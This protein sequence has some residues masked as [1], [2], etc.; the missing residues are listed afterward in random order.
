METNLALSPHLSKVQR[1]GQ[2]LPTSL[3]WSPDSATVAVG[4]EDARFVVWHLLA[5]AEPEAF[6]DV[7]LP[8]G[9]TTGS[10]P[11]AVLAL[12]WIG[13]SV[14][15]VMDDGRIVTSDSTTGRQSATQLPGIEKIAKLAV[16]PHGGLLVSDFNDEAIRVFRCTLAQ[17]TR[18]ARCT[19]NSLAS[20]RP[21]GLALDDAR[22]VAAI[23]FEDGSLRIVGF[24]DQKFDISPEL[25]DLKRV[26]SLA[27]SSDGKHLGIGTFD[28]RTIIADPRGG[29]PF[30]APIGTTSVS[31]MAWDPPGGGLPR[32]VMGTQSASGV[33]LQ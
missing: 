20:G 9:A 23:G 14:V 5:S 4:G 3:A 22:S 2:L 7:K 19:A 33:C 11:P 16:G 29:T 15:A 24:G 25:G 17:D 21:S 12:A 13:A 32:P 18:A 27:F 6:A 1:V 8:K 26:V 30:E 31:A 28:G 10:R